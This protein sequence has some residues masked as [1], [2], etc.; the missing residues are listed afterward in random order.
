MLTLTKT[1]EDIME[2][3]RNIGKYAKELTKIGVNLIAF[4][5]V[6]EILFK[7]AEIPFWPNISVVDNIMGILGGLSNEGLIGLV[8]AFILYHFLKKDDY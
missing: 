4:G 8:G 1:K 5:I 3:L 6:V 2:L 7:G